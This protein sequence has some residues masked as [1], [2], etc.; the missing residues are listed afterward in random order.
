MYT[1]NVIAAPVLVAACKCVL[2]CSNVQRQSNRYIR[3]WLSNRGVEYMACDRRLLFCRH[4]LC[5]LFWVRRGGKVVREGFDARYCA[6]G[7]HTIVSRY[8]E[9]HAVFNCA[10][11]A[12]EIGSLL[13]RLEVIA[14]LKI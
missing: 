1:R 12:V 5:C 4:G 13:R 7:G 9:L 3:C 14:K 8:S 6:G 2:A 10:I 11:G